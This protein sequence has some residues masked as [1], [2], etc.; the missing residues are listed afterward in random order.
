M[1]VADADGVATVGGWAQGRGGRPGFRGGARGAR[2]EAHDGGSRGAVPGAGRRGRVVSLSAAHTL[3]A[4][5]EPAVNEPLL[6][7]SPRVRCAVCVCAWQG[8]RRRHEVIRHAACPRASSR[9]GGKVCKRVRSL[10]LPHRAGEASAAEAEGGARAVPGRGRRRLPETSGAPQTTTPGQR[11]AWVCG[12]ACRP[13]AGG[14]AGERQGNAGGYGGLAGNRKR[15]SHG[16]LQ[17][18]NG[19]CG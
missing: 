4:R 14:A 17:L 13:R 16:G 3:A 10:W 9:A 19:T 7:A 18:H 2:M 11:T 8:W 6:I 12:A 5:L 15:D 1:R